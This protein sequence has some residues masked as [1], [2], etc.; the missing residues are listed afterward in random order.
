MK[1]DK[2]PPGGLNSCPEG[3]K[4]AGLQRLSG[5]Q[6]IVNPLSSVYRQCRHCQE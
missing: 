1:G 4:T 5:G 2:Y 6:S 3:L